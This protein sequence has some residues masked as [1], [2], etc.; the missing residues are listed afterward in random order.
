MSGPEIPP[1][2]HKDDRLPLPPDYQILEL[3]PALLGHLQGD[4]LKNT[5]RRRSIGHKRQFQMI[6]YPIHHGILREE[7][8]G[9]HPCQLVHSEV[10]LFALTG[11]EL[12]YDSSRLIVGVGVGF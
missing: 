3:F 10:E 4:L 6:N 8:N 2:P 11:F 1:P 9:P 5:R 7:G 12:T